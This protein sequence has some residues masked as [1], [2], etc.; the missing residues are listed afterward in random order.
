MG[1]TKKNLFNFYLDD[2]VKLA[3]QNKLI[4]TVGGQPKGQLAALIRV[5][6]KLYIATPDD[7]TNKLLTDAIAAEYEFSQKLNKRSRL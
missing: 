6:L 4:R 2:D 1:T 5:L 3:A 7:K